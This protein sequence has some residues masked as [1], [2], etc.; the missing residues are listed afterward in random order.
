MARYVFCR[1]SSWQVGGLAWGPEDQICPCHGLEWSESGS[2]LWEAVGR[3]IGLQV[4][5]HF[6]AFFRAAYGLM[7]KFWPNFAPQ[8]F[9]G[10]W[11]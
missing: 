7:T 8:G 10:H 4:E 2:G 6:P 3:A 9:L 1:S 5:V 11:K